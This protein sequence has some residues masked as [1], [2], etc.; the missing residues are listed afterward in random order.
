MERYAL[1]PTIQCGTVP[2]ELLRLFEQRSRINIFHKSVSLAYLNGL[3]TREDEVLKLL[4]WMRINSLREG[5]ARGK[6]AHLF[7]S[8]PWRSRRSCV[9]V[10]SPVNSVQR[11]TSTKVN[12]ACILS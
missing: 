11:P 8:L 5:V 6:G 2:R 12:L 10:P 1:A 7:L 4:Q 9:C 3:I